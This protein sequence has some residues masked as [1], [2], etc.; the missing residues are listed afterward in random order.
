MQQQVCTST[1]STGATPLNYL[2]TLPNAY[3]VDSTVQW[4]LL[5]FLHGRGE[6]GQDLDLLKKYGIPKRLTEVDDFSFITISPQCPAD[7]DWEAHDAT[8]ID[9]V[10]EMIATYAVD[11][12]RL[13]LTGLS[14]GGRGAWRLAML[15]PNRFAALA[16]ICGRIPD[17]PGFLDNLSSLRHLPIWVFHGAKDQVVPIEN[18]QKI[19]AALQTW[20]SNVQFT[21]YPEA[22]H[23]AW[24]AT[25][26]N[27]TLY[28]W[29]S[30][31]A[32]VD[33]LN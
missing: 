27:P 6:C 23:D 2:L 4:P 16:P 18:S 26:A 5:L 7:S 24:T 15:N 31:R 17:L 11:N 1:P 32:T 22:D 28:T 20:G 10:D 8:L 12:Q 13:Y 29:L 9:L 14:M 30:Q 21:V 25:Y 19:V 3:G 33:K